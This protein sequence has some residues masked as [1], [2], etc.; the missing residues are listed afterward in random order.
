MSIIHYPVGNYFPI[1]G[2]SQIT[3]TQATHVPAHGSGGRISI[4][5]SAFA[6]P[7]GATAGTWAFAYAQTG[8]LLAAGALAGIAAMTMAPSATGQGAGVLAGQLAIA[9]T[10]SGTLTAPGDISGTT[11]FATTESG[12][13]LGAGA[14]A[15]TSAM[16]NTESATMAGAGALAGS[17]TLSNTDTAAGSVSGGATDIT[18]LDQPYATYAVQRRMRL[19]QSNPLVKNAVFVWAGH[20]ALG[21][22]CPNVPTNVSANVVKVVK[23]RSVGWA[24][25]GGSGNSAAMNYGTNWRTDN[26]GATAATWAFYGTTSVVASTAFAQHN[27][28]GSSAGWEAG[29]IAT[30]DGNGGPGLGFI[31]ARSVTNGHYAI[32]ETP[33]LNTPFTAVYTGDGVMATAANCAIY[34]NGKKGTQNR[35]VAANGT[36]SHDTGDTLLLGRNR[37]DSNIAHNGNIYL[38]ILCARQWTAAEAKSFSLDPW[39]IFSF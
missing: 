31:I 26:M 34:L 29:Y 6:A 2:S 5:F 33:A 23:D 4:T 21:I 19:N 37:M 18:T 7:A 32:S 11:T 9:S 16:A 10:E 35:F 12:T 27:D 39:Q 8:T 25:N 36:T 13:V 24:F 30:A 22:Y 17:V 3:E 15:G 20:S 38:A 14:L 28:G 1:P